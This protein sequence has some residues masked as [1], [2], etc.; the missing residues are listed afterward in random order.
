MLT[1]ATVGDFRRRKRLENKHWDMSSESERRWIQD[2]LLAA[3]RYIR[4]NSGMRDFF[5]FYEEHQFAI[6][7]KYYDLS[8]RRR[9][10]A[11]IL[12]D[13]DL[14]ECVYVK[15]EQDVTLTADT[16]YFF[17]E[18]NIYPKYAVA[19][20]FPQY[21]TGSS[22]TVTALGHIAQPAVKVKALWGY[23]DDYRY[24]WVDTLERVATNGITSSATTLELTE[25]DGNDEDG[26]SPRI[27]EGQLLRIEDELLEVISL[28]D[29]NTLTVKRG[30]RGSTAA[31][32]AQTTVIKKWRVHEDIAQAC[33]QI[34]KTWREANESKGGR[35]G[36]SDMS[37]GVELAVPRDPATIIKSY[38]RVWNSNEE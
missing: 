35:Q 14:L 22:Y 11:D 30:A 31:A 37:T 24:A 13:N 9:T 17:R 19:L 25:L 29:N 7:Y 16:N 12:L 33:Y 15:N 38:R 3:T 32:H 8:M 4:R 1:L 5:P 20:K 23:H 34:A 27:E 36:V 26:L 18:L 10:A 28:T 6:P 21:W 2:E